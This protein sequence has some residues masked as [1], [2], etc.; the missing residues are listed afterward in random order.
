MSGRSGVESEV[1]LVITNFRPRSV[2]RSRSAAAPGFKGLGSSAEQLMITVI[3]V[4]LED[5][6]SVEISNTGVGNR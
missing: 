4:H 5:S 2:F 3:P 6:E 1:Y